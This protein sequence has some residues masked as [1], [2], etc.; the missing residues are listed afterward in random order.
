MIR[1][2]LFAAIV[3]T[4]AAGITAPAAA[5]DIYIQVA[6]PPLRV[7]AVPAPR[8]GYVWVP[9]Y[10]NSRNHKYVWTS[11]TWLRERPGYGYHPSTW[12]EHEGRWSMQR[13]SWTRDRD[14][15]GVPD[16][17]DGHPDN[18]HRN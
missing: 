2:I 3:A 7:Q 12:T 6:P 8:H 18:P 13:G 17:V 14:G 15:D 4:S 16:R 9:G 5:S 1:R 10:W 11:G